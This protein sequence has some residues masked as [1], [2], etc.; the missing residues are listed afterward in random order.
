MT[1]AATH[2]G[3]AE[4]A[5]QGEGR[6][7]NTE[8]GW[9]SARW[10]A[11]LRQTLQ[12]SQ[13]GRMGYSGHTE[14]APALEGTLYVS[15]RFGF[16]ATVEREAFSLVID[17]AP[18]RGG[19]L[20]AATVGPTLRL[21]VGRLRLE[22]LA[23]YG[24]A[25]LPY[26]ADPA[27]PALTPVARH[28]VMAGGRAA[29]QFSERGVVQVRAALPVYS[30]ARVTRDDAGR[31]T[32]FEAGLGVSYAVWSTPRLV[33]ALDADVLYL[34]DTFVTRTSRS[35]QQQRT[36][37]G[38]GLR[39]SF[40]GPPPPPDPV[41]GELRAVVVDADSGGVLP[42]ATVALE[43]VTG[44]PP[45][46]TA[47][48]GS[49]TF[50]D[51][52]PG[53]VAVRAEVQG[54]IPGGAEAAVKVDETAVVKLL[55]RRVPPPQAR[56]FVE[57]VHK[58]SGEKVAGAVVTAMG[59]DHLTSL[60]T[61]LLS[62]V[63]PG[64]LPITVRAPGFTEAEETVSVVA[65][66]EARLTVSLQPTQ[67]RALATIIGHVRDPKGRPI[68]A[69]LSLP[70]AQISTRADETGAFLVRVVGGTYSVIVSAPGYVTQTRTVNVK[71]A[72][73]IIFNITLRP[74]RR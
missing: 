61:V 16:A 12:T 53:P 30:V 74:S 70:Q 2:V 48:D 59:K 45:R 58:L 11:T 44:A 63:P 34:G 50:E 21:E 71:D 23:A 24:F 37:F 5:V 47:Q 13:L 69:L 55:L 28:A 60:G 7:F 64:L 54:Y 41:Y 9:L 51:V 46:T 38:L 67:V 10:G 31:S 36:R 56:V 6:S 26:F 27:A 43:G 8:R 35:I 3:A 42:G 52:A 25:Q 57:V 66:D 4:V 17:G 72:D 62:D 33:Y 19:A 65:G 68:A 15:R 18:G 29:F 39:V 1:L 20:V 22:A 73:Q 40:R 32:G 49:T 14:N